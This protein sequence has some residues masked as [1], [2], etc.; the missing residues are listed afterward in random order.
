[1]ERGGQLICSEMSSRGPR[2]RGGGESERELGLH[3]FTN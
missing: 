1:V 3:L 2:K